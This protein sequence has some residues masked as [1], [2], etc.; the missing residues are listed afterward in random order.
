[1]TNCTRFLKIRQFALFL[2]IFSFC[3]LPAEE[4]DD[5]KLTKSSASVTC[6]IN[7]LGSSQD[8]SELYSNFVH[9]GNTGDVSNLNTRLT[10]IDTNLAAKATSAQATDIQGTNFDTTTDSLHTISGKVATATGLTSAVAPLATSAQVTTAQTNIQG[11]A[12][13]DGLTLGAIEG[14]GFT[15]STNSLVAVKNAVTTLGTSALATSTQATDI[16]GTG[17]AT[18]TNSLVK[19][20]GIGFNTATDNLHA[21][22][23]KV[24]T[25]AG[26]ASAVGPLATSTQAT[27]IQGASFDTTT[28]S[29][30]V[31]SGKVAT[32]TGLTSAVAPLATSAQVTTAQTNIQGTAADSTNQTIGALQGTG[33][34]A[35]DNLHNIKAAVTTLGTSALATAANLTTLQSTANTINTNMATAANLLALGSSTD[36][37]SLNLL[38]VILQT[39]IIELAANNPAL[40]TTYAGSTAGG[41]SPASINTAL[42]LVASSTDTLITNLYDYIKAPTAGK[43]TTIN[44]NITSVQTNITSVTTALTNHISGS[45]TVSSPFS[46][47]RIINSLNR[48]SYSITAIQEVPL[49]L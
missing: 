41:V 42:G 33:F 12:G 34:A 46:D 11:T 21:I 6:A 2:I 1:M 18:G 3:T 14:T 15:S 5:A 10:T 8:S 17:F 45:G 13:T 37:S 19:I 35:G 16:Q 43:I 31:I 30:H 40:L 23:S 28:D 4:Y 49:N 22:S 38:P 39:G 29:L 36:T 25:T 32:A 9:L 48:L 24:A 26:L 47:A 27:N 44:T 7:A 20:C